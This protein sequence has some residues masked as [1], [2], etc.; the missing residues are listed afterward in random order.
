[1]KDIAVIV[2]HPDDEVLAF[3]GLMARQSARG[4]TIHVLIM[5]TGLSSRTDTVQLD[6]DELEKLRADC[7]SANE[8]LGVKNVQFEN[9][10]DNRM[11]S[12][13][14]L[15]VIKP[16]ERFLAETGATQIY[17]H[18]LGD[19]NV[20]HKAVAMAVATAAR[21][22]PGG[23]FER[24]CSGEVL[25]SSE[26]SFHENRFMPN[27]Y[28]DISG[29]VDLKCQ[30]MACYKSEIRS[31]PHPRSLEAIR[32]AAALRGSESGFE[33]AEALNVVRD[34]YR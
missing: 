19:L 11:D 3:G 4:D 7:L 17:T 16:V 26:F 28:A 21:T 9:F 30:A 23:K 14:L 33:A 31:W 20:D 12:V 34:I 32:A 27:S 18:H 2:A 22:L 15:D 10:P 1:M 24:M 6:R 5:A 8:I 13:A 25:S 29:F